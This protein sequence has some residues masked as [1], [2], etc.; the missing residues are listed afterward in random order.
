[1]QP[2]KSKI[3]V[4]GPCA[5]E[6]EEQVL[7][8]A[9]AV[10]GLGVQT[11]FRAGI[12]KPRTSPETFQ[13]IGA[14]G[15][16][17]LVKAQAETGMIATTE[18]STPEQ[19]K[20]SL[21]AGLRGIWIGARTGADPIAVQHLA[22]ALRE[23]DKKAEVVLV[24]NP[25][26]EDVDLWIG[27]IRRIQSAVPTTT[28][29]IAVHRGCNHRP[30]W[31]MAYALKQAMP[32]MPLLLDP[33]HMSGEADKVQ[34]LVNKAAALGYDGYMIEVH[35]TPS[36]ALSDSRQQITPEQLKDILEQVIQ[37]EPVGH[38]ELLWLRAQ[39]DEVDD[40]L[41]SAL[42]E[43]LNVVRQIGQYKHQHGL[44][45]YQPERY[46]SM[47]AERLIWAKKNGLPE[48]TVRSI[49]DAIHSA[50]VGLQQH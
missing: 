26:N 42:A 6:T 20:E 41:W 7:A 33:S 34:A 48:E 25:V 43:R 46:Q 5:A 32:E 29:V 4:V 10:A 30:C 35:P 16:P 40:R 21:Q 50:S 17:W 23:A 13:G 15:L 1:M 36:Q 18:V 38:N 2:C 24:K 31:R 22:D 27:N 9:R 19:L 49:L 3:L 11:I 14:K 45:A 39:I 44:E 12:W 28:D 47:M 37:V 8:T